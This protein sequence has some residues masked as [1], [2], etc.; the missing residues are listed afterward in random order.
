MGA[1]VDVGVGGICQS[2][3]AS[4]RFSKADPVL[5]QGVPC[6]TGAL[7]ISSSGGGL[8]SR[9]DWGLPVGHGTSVNFPVANWYT[10]TSID[11]A[12]DLATGIWVEVVVT[13]GV[14]GSW[15]C[16][17]RYRLGKYPYLILSLDEHSSFFLSYTSGPWGFPSHGVGIL[18][19]GIG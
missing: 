7:G 11:A 19:T 6:L 17:G 10:I 9:T 2:F 16:G 1:G 12:V 3:L 18:G 8:E 15:G 4:N 13:V 14:S 5:D